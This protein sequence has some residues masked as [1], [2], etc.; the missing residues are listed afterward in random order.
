MIFI[1]VGGNGCSLS[2][3]HAS[4]HHI[5]MKKATEK[6]PREEFPLGDGA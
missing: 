5:S 6:A 4:A 3:L 2:G 1:L